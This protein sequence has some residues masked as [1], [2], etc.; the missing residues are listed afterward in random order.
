MLLEKTCSKC[1]QT[2]PVKSF[3]YDRH[4]KGGRRNFCKECDAEKVRQYRVDHPEQVRLA[5]R[6]WQRNN[7]DKVRAS[8][9]RWEQNN[10]EKLKTMRRAWYRANSLRI[11]EETR[12]KRH[13]LRDEVI[14]A[15]GGCCGCCGENAALFLTLDHVEQNGSMHRR[16][17]GGNA[18]SIYK[19]AKENNFP[20]TLRVLCYN[21]N[22]GSWRNKGVCP[23]EEMKRSILKLV[24]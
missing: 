22:C 10:P 23:H 6:N 19:W 8:T 4:K 13:K 24:G 11:A 14:N 7:K 21:C 1:G 5:G 17:L 2:L 20:P 15:Y 18:D 3:S 12:N 16:A 9:K